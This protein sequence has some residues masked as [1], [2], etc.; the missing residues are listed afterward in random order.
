M[1]RILVG[2]IATTLACLISACG[3]N[4]DPTSGQASIEFYNEMTNSRLFATA[5]SVTV[6]VSDS[7]STVLS[8]VKYSTGNANNA[9]S[10]TVNDGKVAFN[11]AL[12]SG[13]AGGGSSSGS[14]SGGSSSGSGGGSSI[15]QDSPSV[16]AN[17]TTTIVLMGDRSTTPANL[18]IASFEQSSDS[19]NSNSVSFR[20]IN[21]L[22]NVG[23]VDVAVGTNAVI[24]PGV[25]F[26]KDSGYQTVT[27]SGRTLDLT[28]TQSGTTNSVSKSCRVQA[29]NHYDVILAYTNFRGSNSTNLTSTDVSIFCHQ[30]L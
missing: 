4:S 29:G 27:Q 7:S 19:V 6:D 9:A 28:I 5:A 14:S 8:K 22:S 13:G 10:A 12:S 1:K 18:T 21:T 26:G 17:S 25:A 20:V 24:A 16:T 3:S 11:I 15:L 23:A 2:G 30:T